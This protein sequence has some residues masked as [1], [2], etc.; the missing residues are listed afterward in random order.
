MF[1]PS[2]QGMH[3]PLDSYAIEINSANMSILLREI[4]MEI[5]RDCERP[6]SVAHNYELHI[7]FRHRYT[8]RCVNVNDVR[9]NCICM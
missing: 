8:E 1:V 9:C 2:L 5:E 3:F 6:K 4:E 7:E